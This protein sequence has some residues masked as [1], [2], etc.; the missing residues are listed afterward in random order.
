[1]APMMPVP[2]DA[3][4]GGDLDRG[5]RATARRSRTTP[6]PRVTSARPASNC[7]FTSTTR[8]PPGAD[9]A[10]QGGGDRPQRDEREI[11]G[12]QV[13]RAGVAE[14]FRPGGADVDP[15]EHLDPRVG[16]RAARSSCP[17][18]TSTATTL[19]AP[20]WSRQ[21][22]NPP[23][24]APASRTPPARDVERRTAP[25]RRRASPRR[26]RRTGAPVRARPRGRPAT[27]AGTACRPGRRRRA[28]APW[29]PP[30]A[31]ALGSRPDA[32]GRARCRAAGARGSGVTRVRG[33][34]QGHDRVGALRDDA[35]RG[36][37][38][39]LLVL[40]VLLLLA[41]DFGFL[42]P[43]APFAP[44]FLPESFFEPGSAVRW[45]R[46]AADDA[47]GWSAT[48]AISA[49]PTSVD[50]S[51]AGSRTGPPRT[52]AIRS[53]SSSSEPTC[54]SWRPS[55]SRARATSWPP[56]SRLARPRSSRSRRARVRVCSS[57]DKSPR[58]ISW[59]RSRVTWPT[60]GR[61]VQITPPALVAGHHSTVVSG[62][63]SPAP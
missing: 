29:R 25:V 61:G 27:R 39:V 23:V 26:A 35:L 43:F 14:Q 52:S 63:P 59:A 60:R 50:G 31:P 8:S 17:W 3:Q 10:D 1:M 6:F 51:R 49:G 48:G 62:R 57:S 24:E 22:M 44:F 28:P 13:D 34:R 32:A 12:E 46:A 40:F 47:P 38:L 58:A 15:L 2:A 20:R 45:D 55:S 56:K 30:R 5:P 4:G 21:S 16:R 18:P 54:L 53:K 7:G 33:S 19:D 37:L 42:S 41:R 9:Q 36:G 11:G